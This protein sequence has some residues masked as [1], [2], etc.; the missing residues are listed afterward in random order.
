MGLLQAP[1]LVE[2][3]SRSIGCLAVMV[4]LSLASSGCA[5]LLILMA[6]TW[7]GGSSLFQLAHLVGGLVLLLAATP[8]GVVGAARVL[9]RR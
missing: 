3:G 1:F 7:G 8:L 6:S 4:G 2:S 5:S 9:G